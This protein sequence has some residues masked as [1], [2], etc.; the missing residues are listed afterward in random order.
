MDGL[1]ER[2]RYRK[3]IFYI[4]Y[5][6]GDPDWVKISLTFVV[7]EIHP[8]SLVCH[9]RGGSESSSILAAR[10]SLHQENLMKLNKIKQF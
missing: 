9:F 7:L 10:G 4:I 6:I 5:Y 3:I 8:V 2:Y 1:G